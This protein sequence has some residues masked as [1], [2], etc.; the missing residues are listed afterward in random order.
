RMLFIDRFKEALN[1]AGRTKTSLALVF[2]DLDNFKNVNDV[3]G[4]A[5]GDI[6]LKEAAGRLVSCLRKVDRSFVV[7]LPTDPKALYVTKAII[8]MAHEPGIKVIA[9]G[10]ETQEQI[11]FLIVMGCD[12]MQGYFFSPPVPQDKMAK[13]LKDG[14]TWVHETINYSRKE[15]QNRLNRNT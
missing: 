1:R 2:I 14:V 12:E 15:M 8:T 6:L 4:H 5:A 10:V 13:L 11:D 9:E 3:L 7:N